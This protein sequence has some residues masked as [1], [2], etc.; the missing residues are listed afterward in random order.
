MHHLSLSHLTLSAT[1]FVHVYQ[2]FQCSAF[3]AVSFHL[4]GVPLKEHLASLSP[5]IHVLEQGDFEV[6]GIWHH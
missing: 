1:M 6:A 5:H 4:S 3:I 2:L